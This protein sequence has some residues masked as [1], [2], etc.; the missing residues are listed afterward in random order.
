M[1][2]QNIFSQPVI[3]SDALEE[4]VAAKP[5]P[6]KNMLEDSKPAAAPKKV[7]AAPK[8]KAVAKPQAKK[9]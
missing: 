5:A 2:V 8:A 3:R 6:A 1:Y 9:K 7:A 4:V